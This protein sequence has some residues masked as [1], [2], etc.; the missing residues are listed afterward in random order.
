MFHRPILP[1]RKIWQK[2]VR[3]G[4][5]HIQETNSI[6]YQSFGILIYYS[7]KLSVENKDWGKLQMNHMKLVLTFPHLCKIIWNFVT[8]TPSFWH[9]NTNSSS[10]VPFW[11]WCAPLHRCISFFF[12]LGVHWG[13]FKLFSP[14]NRTVPYNPWASRWRFPVWPILQVLIILCM[15]TITYVYNC[16]NLLCTHTQ[17]QQCPVITLNPPQQ[18]ETWPVPYPNS[19]LC[20]HSTSAF[21]D[22]RHY[23]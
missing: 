20:F 23:S 5:F 15:H 17:Q 13:F 4:N 21:T 10:G 9:N 19:C 18:S 11:S 22:T 3:L 14:F 12:N 16:K 1:S 8:G 2:D 6:H 7:H